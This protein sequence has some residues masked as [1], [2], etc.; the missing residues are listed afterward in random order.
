MN[1]YKF[2]NWLESRG[3]EILPTTN[4]HEALRFKGS[5]VGVVYKTGNTSGVYT[6]HA[7]DCF[8]KKKTWT[9]KP[10]NVGRNKSYKKEK[11]QLIA[12]DGS[13]CFFCDNELNDD[14]TVEHL[15]S[16]SSGG[17]NTLANMVLA[18]ASCN[19]D[20]SNV[21]V[22]EKVKTAIRKRINREDLTLKTKHS[23]Y[24]SIGSIVEVN[25]QKPMALYKMTLE[26]AIALKNFLILHIHRNFN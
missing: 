6:D 10:I 16:L 8:K 21:Q 13:R 12:R 19:N 22:Q 14:I 9:G 17:K 7:I 3:C 4:P 11:R 15:I 2:Q 23:E 20:V 1:L 25:Y 5:S 26:D 24:E 18:H